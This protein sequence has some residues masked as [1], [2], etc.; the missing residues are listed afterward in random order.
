[1]Q[2]ALLDG[3]H[4]DVLTVDSPYMRE[5]KRRIW[6]VFKNWISKI[7]L[8]TDFQLFC[9]TLTPTLPLQISPMR[10]LTMNGKYFPYRSRR[11]K[12][13][14]SFYPSHSYSSWKMRLETSRRKAL[15]YE[16]VL[17]YTHK[18]TQAI[19]SLFLW[20]TEE[21]TSEVTKISTVA[22]AFLHFSLR[23]VS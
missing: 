3:L 7:H 21:P 9:I 22:Y 15:S 2:N 1:M 5:M 16:D 23:N 17:Q 11:A 8:S 4:S 10:I 14:Y 13:P 19:Y 12:I 6:A 18:L 20:G